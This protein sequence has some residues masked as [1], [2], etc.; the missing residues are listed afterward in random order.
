MRHALA[1]WR[2]AVGV[3]R[4]QSHDVLLAVSEAAA[5]AV[6]HGYRSDPAGTV[7]LEAWANEDSVHVAVHDAGTWRTP[8]RGSERGRGRA[9]MEALMR[10]V[11]FESDGHGTV[12]R[13]RLTL[14]RPLIG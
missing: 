1:T 6:E 13:M 3:D 7:R 10:D 4:A 8:R 9:I 5:N 14:T 11:T 12:V 2:D